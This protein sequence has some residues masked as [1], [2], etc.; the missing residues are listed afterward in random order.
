MKPAELL[1]IYPTRVV[2]PDF[3]ANDTREGH[4]LVPQL[5]NAEA[6]R[7]WPAITTHNHDNHAIRT[8]NWRYIRYA[9]GSEEL[10]E[11]AKDTNELSN[12]L[13]PGDTGKKTE[14]RTQAEQKAKWIASVNRRQEAGS[15][16]RVLTYET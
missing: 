15:A 3:P 6:P 12:L 14:A 4:S 1:D 8:E 16:R 7:K 11:M 9:D 2:L 13:P 5:E 10:Y